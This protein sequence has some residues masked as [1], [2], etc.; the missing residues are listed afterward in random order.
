MGD[1]MKILIE[2]FGESIEIGYIGTREQIELQKSIEY[3][4][5]QLPIVCENLA[6]ALRASLANAFEN[7]ARGFCQ[8]SRDLRGG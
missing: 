6:N 5:E 8:M 4:T 7:M 3:V 1:I 2:S